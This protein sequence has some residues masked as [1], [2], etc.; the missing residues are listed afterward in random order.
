MM[1][2]LVL[3]KPKSKNNT[4][5]IDYIIREVVVIFLKCTQQCDDSFSQVHD[6]WSKLEEVKLRHGNKGKSPLVTDIVTNDDHI[7][8]EVVV[9]FK[10][11]RCTKLLLLLLLMQQVMV[12]NNTAPFYHILRRGMTSAVQVIAV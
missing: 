8:G 4:T 3:P 9:G 1:S 12:L 5:T 2:R 11:K 10:R 6:A 7:T